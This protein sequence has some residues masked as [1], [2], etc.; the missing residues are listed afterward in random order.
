MNE[1]IITLSEILNEKGAILALT[2]AF[3][4]G[5][6][7]SM[8]PCNIAIIPLFLSYLNKMPISINIKEARVKGFLLSLSFIIGIAITFVLLGLVLSL[9]GGLLGTPQRI[10]QYILAFISLLMGLTLLEVIRFNFKIGNFSIEQYVNVK[11]LH[12][13][14]GALLLG[15]VLGLTS[16]QCGTPIMFVIL[17]FV[18]L[19]GKVI[20]GALLMFFYALGRGIPL[21]V[22]GTLSNS[23]R[24]HPKF[25]QFSPLLQ[26][27][28]GILLLLL[29]LYFVYSA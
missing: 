9:I 18:T 7:T 23:F 15:M 19:K 29:A 16:S 1:F 11:K 22:L 10:F 4:G 21:L 5:I 24:I 26:K 6:L 25:S 13:F 17:S 28:T 8:G 2:I 14:M 3:L 20:L 12:G 27:G